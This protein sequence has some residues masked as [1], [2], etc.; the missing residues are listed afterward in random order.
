V[1]SS[2][3]PEFIKVIEIDLP[4]VLCFC[5]AGQG[6]VDIGQRPP[7]RGDSS[8]TF[9]PVSIEDGLFGQTLS[10]RDTQALLGFCG[11]RRST[12]PLRR[13]GLFF[14]ILLGE[15]LFV[16][17]KF[18]WSATA[19]L[20]MQTLDA[21]VFPFLDPGRHS[22]AMDLIGLCNSLDGRAAALSNRLWARLR[23]RNAM[24][25]C[26]VFSRSS[27]CSSVKGCTYLTIIPSS[28]VGEYATKKRLDVDEV[29]YQHCVKKLLV[30]YLRLIHS[31]A[32]IEDQMRRRSSTTAAIGRLCRTRSSPAL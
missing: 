8:T 14:D 29:L 24:S 16:W 9:L 11:P 2:A 15:F 13:T 25:S 20:I 23:A 19:R 7:D 4:L 31:S 18:A 30:G 32:S 3:K 17:R 10:V 27:R 5:K 12:T 21:M 6:H 22:D 1:G 28:G 26:I